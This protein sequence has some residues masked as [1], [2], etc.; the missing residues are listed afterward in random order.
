MQSEVRTFVLKTDLHRVEYVYSARD[1]GSKLKI[2]DHL[3]SITP[4]YVLSL[5]D[6]SDLALTQRIVVETAQG[7]FT[8]I[9]SA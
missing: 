8:S 2:N 5:D 7:F 1:A 3:K 4:I 6:E 9:A